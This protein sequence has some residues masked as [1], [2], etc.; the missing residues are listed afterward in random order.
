MYTSRKVGIEYITFQ[1]KNLAKLILYCDCFQSKLQFYSIRLSTSLPL[2]S[3]LVLVSEASVVNVYYNIHIVIELSKQK[4]G[5]SYL[6]SQ[7]EF[8]WLVERE[9]LQ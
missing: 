2:N 8:N 5:L 9:N 7:Q 3:N 6:D 4:S 1:K